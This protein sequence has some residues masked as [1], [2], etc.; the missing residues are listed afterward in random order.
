MDYATVVVLLLAGLLV[1]VAAMV[2]VV[3]HRRSVARRPEPSSIESAVEAETPDDAAIIVTE[4]VSDSDVGELM[5]DAIPIDPL[6]ELATQLRHTAGPAVQAMT[7][8]T[9]KRG[10]VLVEFSAN[11]TSALRSGG[12]KFLQRVDGSLQPTLVGGGSRIAEN[13]TI[14]GRGGQ[15]AMTAAAVARVAIL[16]AVQA[17]LVSME[18]T[19]D[20]MEAKVD[21]LQRFLDDKE[22]ARVRSRMRKLAELRDEIS[23]AESPADMQTWLIVLELADLAFLETEDFAKLR[24]SDAAASLGRSGLQVQWFGPSGDA[25]LGSFWNERDRY[26]LFADLQALAIAG[27]LA[28]AQLK[29]ACGRER[30]IDQLGRDVETFAAEASRHQEFLERRGREFRTKFRKRLHEDG[31]RKEVLEAAA[32]FQKRSDGAIATLRGEVQRLGGAGRR[33]VRTIVEI[34]EHGTVRPVALL[35]G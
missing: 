28:V 1:A 10:R 6:S 8:L 12:V 23:R 14:V 33:S 3:R 16:L 19:L 11:G 17:Q 20:R 13:A 24:C 5:R 25:L 32:T 22:V 7:A 27:R 29:A 31:R 30:R 18:R 2:T 21:A 34:D 15:L 4:L 26:E 9:G 35:Q